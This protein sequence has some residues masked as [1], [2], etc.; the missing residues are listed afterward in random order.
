M[1]KV[2][3]TDIISAIEILQANPTARSLTY[4]CG[5]LSDIKTRIRLTRPYYKRGRFD[6]RCFTVVM[7]IGRPNFAEREFIK[8]CRKAKTKPCRWW[9]G[10]WA[11]K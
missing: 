6:I 3:R 2:L 5:N 4:F 7:S 1:M 11:K 9:I 10:R 8:L